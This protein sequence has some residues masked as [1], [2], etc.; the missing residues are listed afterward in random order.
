MKRYYFLIEMSGTGKS[1][2]EAWIDAIKG[3]ELDPGCC[4]PVESIDDI[5]D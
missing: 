2:E 4:P 5:D 1:P 3:F